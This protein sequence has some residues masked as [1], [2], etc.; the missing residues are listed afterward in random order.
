M[1][2]RVQL[3]D[4][5]FAEF[6]VTCLDDY[7]ISSPSSSWHQQANNRPQSNPNLVL[8]LSKELTRLRIVHKLYKGFP[9]FFKPPCLSNLPDPAMWLGCRWRFLRSVPTRSAEITIVT[10][11]AI[12]L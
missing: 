5:L 2:D 3:K 9:L 8:I 12:I 6:I 7:C 4:V 10:S 11:D 1:R